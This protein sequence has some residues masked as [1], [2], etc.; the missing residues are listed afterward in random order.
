MGSQLQT[1]SF[2][3]DQPQQAMRTFS[4]AGGP[5]SA[6]F[7]LVLVQNSYPLTTYNVYSGTVFGGRHFH[8][9]QAVLFVGRCAMSYL[10]FAKELPKSSRLCYMC[11]R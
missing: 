7:F 5:P 1:P 11:L 3:V 10:R 8:R 9:E 4:R 6:H 2:R